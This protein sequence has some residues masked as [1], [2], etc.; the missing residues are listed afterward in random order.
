MKNEGPQGEKHSPDSVHP[1]RLSM[2]KRLDRLVAGAEKFRVGAEKLLVAVETDRKE[3]KGHR[4]NLARALEDEFIASL[5][6][7]V[8]EAYDIVIEP[9]DIIPRKKLSVGKAADRV[10]GEIDFIAPNG[11][12]VLVGEVKNHLL[13]Q[14]VSALYGVLDLVREWFPEY[15]DLR[16]HGV[17]AGALIDKAAEERALKRGFIIMRK[18]G[19]GIHPATGKNFQ[20]TA[21]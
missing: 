1:R 6:R 21:Y 9:E 8:K 18:D 4:A 20:P 19:A 16:V 12:L 5:P 11:K 2:D 17:V 10:K 13:L 14:D 7:V 15:A 3:N